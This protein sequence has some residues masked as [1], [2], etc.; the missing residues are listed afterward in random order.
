MPTH[1]MVSDLLQRLDLHGDVK[2][3]DDVRR[4]LRQGPRQSLHDLGAIGKDR[5]LAAASIALALQGLQRPGLK[6]ALGCVGGRE[7]AARARAAPAAP[8]GERSRPCC[9]STPR[10]SP[11][12]LY[13]RAR[14]CISTAHR[15]EGVTERLARP[16]RTGR[17]LTLSRGAAAR[18]L[19]VSSIPWRQLLRRCQGLRA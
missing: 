19:P 7:I 9:I 17:P 1:G 5:D 13:A 15:R 6:L 18:G 16:G 4:R 2:P 14:L 10:I 11:R 12:A 8:G 3:V